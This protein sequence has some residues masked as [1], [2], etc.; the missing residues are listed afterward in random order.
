MRQMETV[1][2]KPQNFMKKISIQTAPLSDLLKV[3]KSKNGK[4]KNII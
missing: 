2:G 3:P 4:L 1:N